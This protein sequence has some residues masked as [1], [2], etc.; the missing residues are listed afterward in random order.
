M[1]LIPEIRHFAATMFTRILILSELL[2]PFWA[3]ALA[4]TV[5]R[6]APIYV[7]DDSFSA[8]DYLTERKIQKKLFARL[9]GKTKILVTQRVS[10]AL[11]ADRIY[12]MDRGRISAVGTH[13]ELIE[14]SDIYREI[15]VS[16]LGKRALG[17]DSNEK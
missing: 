11:A 17:G 5:I 3:I 8:L 6:E 15:C 2:C 13:K 1:L 12:V 10:T 9:K 16:Q 14:S 7:F 4:R